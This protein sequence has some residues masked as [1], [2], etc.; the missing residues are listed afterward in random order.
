MLPNHHKTNGSVVVTF[1]TSLLA[2][3]KTY[4]LYT[5]KAVE[6]G[7]VYFSETDSADAVIRTTIQEVHEV[8]SRP[9]M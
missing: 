1:T 5:P 8:K 3:L 9:P 4:P 2:S 6:K 7:I